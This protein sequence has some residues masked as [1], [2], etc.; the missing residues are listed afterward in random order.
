MPKKSNVN[1]K[2]RVGAIGVGFSIATVYV[3]LVAHAS[4]TSFKAGYLGYFGI[5]IRHVNY[6]PSIADF[7][8]EP[9]FVLISITTLLAVCF[10]AILLINLVHWLTLKLAKKYKW[11]WVR[12]YFEEK[13]YGLKLTLGIIIALFLFLSIKLPLYDAYDRGVTSAKDQKNFTII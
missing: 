11:K 12:E 13:P 2:D 9:L 1:I 6:W 10:G 8:N 7:M 4:A 3:V 5:D